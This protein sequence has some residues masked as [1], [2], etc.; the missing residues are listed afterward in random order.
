M[1]VYYSIFAYTCLI[2][3]LGCYFYRRKLANGP[4][5][6]D[7]AY[8]VKAEK[9][10]SL[11]WAAVSVFLLVFFVSYR[12]EYNDTISYINMF[13]NASV[14]TSAKELF[15]STSTNSQGFNTLMV[16][17][18]K[19]ISDDYTAWFTFLAIFHA[20][21][22][23]LLYYRYSCNY[24]LSMYL[25]IASGSFSW[26]MAGIRQFTA[27]CLVLYFFNLV[28]SRRLI[29]FAIVLYLA[30]TIHDSAI[31]W[32]PIYFIVKFKPF[33]KQI[34]ICV[35]MTL[36]VFFFITEFT[37]FL[38]TSLE[39]TDYE[40]YGSALSGGVKIGNEVDD[41]VNPIIA[42]I[43]AVPPAIA[44]WRWKYIKDRT[45]PMIDI[46]INMGTAAVGVNLL[47]VVTSGVLVGRVPIFFTPVNFIVLPWLFKYGLYGNVKKIVVALCYILYFAYF[48]YY[49]VGIGRGYYGSEKLG[50]AFYN[51]FY[52]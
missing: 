3:Y 47:G 1:I 45:N 24:F 38:D 13:N 40:K 4:Q 12:S 14:N 41:G 28:I 8:L 37:S 51:S 50:I 26:M 17:F 42:I 6:E 9:S 25:F 16:L 29:G 31:F 11:F 10:I 52:G 27:V 20:G 22:I 34:W 5:I 23:V 18:K 36:I 7:D 30:Y 44:L 48:L 49:M 2:S 15:G 33:S 19:Y 39:G 35:I 21:A 43:S 32:V 46:C